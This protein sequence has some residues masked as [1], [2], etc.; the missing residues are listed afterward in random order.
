MEDLGLY[1]EFIRAMA[2]VSSKIIMQYYRTPIS[3]ESKEDASPVT[4]ADKR[5]EETLR[6]LIMKGFPSHGIIGEE[7]GNYN[8]D[9]EYLWVLDPIDGT[10]SFISGSPNFGTLIALL[11]N[12][13]P[14]LGAISLP[15]FGEL[16][17]GDSETAELN[18]QRVSMRQCSS[19]REAS[20]LTTDYKD[21]IKYRDREK[22]DF[23]MN[24]CKIFRT[25]GDCFGYYLLATGYADIMV[26]PIMSVWDLM[27]LIPIIKGAGGVITDFKGG[28]PAKGDS[29]I[30]A[31]VPMH[32]KVLGL[33]N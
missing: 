11:K 31:N 25:W 19:L 1:K 13:E 3:V 26:D 29:I 30:A 2:S 12:K 22:F 23:L 7:F 4:I 10:K 21:V 18:S 28:D 17:I 5:T 24:S 27:A 8:E 20:L 16:L 33:L 32:E 6:N 15:V 14:I 9:A